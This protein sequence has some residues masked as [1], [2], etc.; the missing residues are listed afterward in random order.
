MIFSFLTAVL[1]LRCPLQAFGEPSR[2]SSTSRLPRHSSPGVTASSVG[3]RPAKQDL[4]YHISLTSQQSQRY[5]VLLRHSASQAGL[6]QPRLFDDS[7]WLG[8]LPT[9]KA[10]D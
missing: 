2:T 7:G 10:G 9:H 8:G 1:A 4:L 6:A 5:S 3:I